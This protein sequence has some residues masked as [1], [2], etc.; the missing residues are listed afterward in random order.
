MGELSQQKSKILKEI[1]ARK[2]KIQ[3]V[4]DELEDTETQLKSLEGEGKS[5]KES[6]QARLNHLKS[7]LITVSLLPK[8]EKQMNQEIE[9]IKKQLVNAVSFED[10]EIQRT[11]LRDRRTELFHQ[12]DQLYKEKKPFNDNYDEVNKRLNVILA[13]VKDTR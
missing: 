7:D 4:A 12:R 5:S 13:S 8:E 3:K 9:Q 2:G 10:I 1:N 11:K 6:L